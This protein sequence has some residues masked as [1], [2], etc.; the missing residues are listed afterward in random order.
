MKDGP[1]CIGC[2]YRIVAADGVDVRVQLCAV[3]ARSAAAARVAGLAHKPPGGEGRRDTW[4]TT[5]AEDLAIVSGIDN[6]RKKKRQQ[7]DVFEH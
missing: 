6:L 2:L 5:S 1:V 3:G 4:P 7:S